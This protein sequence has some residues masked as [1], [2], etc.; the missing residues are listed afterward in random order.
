[1]RTLVVL[2][3]PRDAAHDIRVEIPEEAALQVRWESRGP[4]GASIPVVP[5]VQ[6]TPAMLMRSLRIVNQER[7]DE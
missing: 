3:R 5:P 2:V 4:L 7:K 6:T 1:M